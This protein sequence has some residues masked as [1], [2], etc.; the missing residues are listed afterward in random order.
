MEKTPFDECIIGNGR[1]AL[2][3]DRVFYAT[4]SSNPLFFLRKNFYDPSPPS[5]WDHKLFIFRFRFEKVSIGKLEGS[6]HL[7]RG[8]VVKNRRWKEGKYLD[9]VITREND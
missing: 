7:F 9:R 4:Q 5:S 8:K 3:I 6:C 2:S 1:A